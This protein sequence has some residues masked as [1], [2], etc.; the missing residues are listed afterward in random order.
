[1]NKGMKY[2]TEGMIAAFVLAPRVPVQAVKPAEIEEQR[3]AGNSAKHWET[4]GKR[5]TTGTR[6]IK[7]DLLNK[8][9]ELN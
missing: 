3:P 4:V 9:P 6:K 8:Q 7:C 1:M 5:M 2:F